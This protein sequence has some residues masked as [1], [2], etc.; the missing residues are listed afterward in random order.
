MKKKKFGTSSF[1]GSFSELEWS[2][3]YYGDVGSSDLSRERLLAKRLHV[4][5][6]GTIGNLKLCI[7]GLAKANPITYL[8]FMN[9][10]WK[11]YQKLTNK[12][13]PRPLL[14]EAINF[15]LK[16]GSG[17]DLGSG[18]LS[19]SK[20]LLDNGFEKVIAVDIEKFEDIND[21][22]FNFIKSKFEDFDFPIET[23][24]LVNAQFALPF[25]K[26]ETLPL[27]FEKLK[28]SL[29]AGG[30]FT[31]QFFG[32]NDSWNHNQNMNFQTK[33]EVLKL[34]ED[35]EIIK[36][37]EMENDGKTASGDIKHWHVFHIIARKK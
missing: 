20:F 12:Q 18:A 29:V 13:I 21:R 36:L 9:H 17:L 28:N 30:I 1:W 34:L 4:I 32:K 7:M 37:K 25:I 16:K 22:R 15:V 10:D 3:R 24:D 27:I 8:F 5:Q 26:Q 35:M 19:E 33:E 2:D 14:V 11:I 6:G 31:G 23:F